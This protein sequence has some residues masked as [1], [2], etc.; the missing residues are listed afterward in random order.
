MN[1]AFISQN[2]DDPQIG[3]KVKNN[4]NDDFNNTEITHC[5]TQD[6]FEGNETDDDN[7]IEDV[8]EDEYNNDHN[9][10]IQIEDDIKDNDN[11]VNNNNKENENRKIVALE[12]KKNAEKSRKVKVR[13]HYRKNKSTYPTSKSPRKKVTQKRLPIIRTKDSS[14][15]YSAHIKN[16]IDLIRGKL[17]PGKK[18]AEEKEHKDE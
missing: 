9:D 3:E 17:S 2:D 7:E 10:E 6:G 15:A 12:W 4:H 8:V 16:L 18:I 1:I 14:M 11:G 13:T 5:I